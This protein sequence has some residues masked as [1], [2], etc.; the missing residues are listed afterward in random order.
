[1]QRESKEEVRARVKARLADKEHFKAPG[2]RTVM[3]SKVNFSQYQKEFLDIYMDYYRE[4]YPNSGP[5]RLLEEAERSMKSM[6]SR[7]ERRLVLALAG[8]KPV[9][10]YQLS[11]K[12]KSDEPFMHLVFV[13]PSYR[14]ARV[15]ELLTAKASYF[16]LSQADTYHRSLT[17]SMLSASEATSD[18][19][20]LR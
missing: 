3:V 11:G 8:S 9:G 14:N 4:L 10:F 7:P 1:M 13:H 2:I 12:F 18:P 6:L 19:A 17:R 20:L 15:S 5:N 16:A